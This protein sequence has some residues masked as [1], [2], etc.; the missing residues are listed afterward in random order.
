V[1]S[2]NFRAFNESVARFAKENPA[3]FKVVRDKVALQ[4][5]AGVVKKSPVDTGRFRANHQ[6]T[7]GAPAGG[8]LEDTDKDGNGTIGNGNGTIVAAPPFGVVYITNNLPY[9]EA[10]ENGHS[11]QAP[12]GVYELTFQELQSQFG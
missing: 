4:G 2:T 10:I 8:D 7:T 5:L 11:G 9:A 3:T 1:A 6:V 12:A